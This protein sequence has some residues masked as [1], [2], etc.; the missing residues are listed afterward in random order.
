MP[1]LNPQHSKFVIFSGG[2]G[3]VERKQ[4]VKIDRPGINSFE[5]MDVPASFDPDTTTVEINNINPVGSAELMQIVA[6]RPDRKYIE[7]YIERERS[8][9]DQ[10]ISE[11][12]N[13]RS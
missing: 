12:V 9:S 5:I 11:S 2:G 7:D 8:A 3:L 1:R 13:L 10:I 6:R 4:M